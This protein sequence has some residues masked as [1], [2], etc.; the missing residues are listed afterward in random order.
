MSV[1]ITIRIDDDNLLPGTRESPLP[2]VLGQ[3]DLNG[4]ALVNRQGPRFDSIK[5]ILEGELNTL[6][7]KCDFC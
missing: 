3:G 1:P 5:I 2:I 7:N 4:I 6:N